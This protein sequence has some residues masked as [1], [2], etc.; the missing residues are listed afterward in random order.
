MKLVQ[1]EQIIFIAVY[2]TKNTDH[3]WPGTS[4]LVSDITCFQGFFSYHE[5]QPILRHFCV[6]HINAPGQDDGAL[7]LKPEYGLSVLVVVAVVSPVFSMPV[8]VKLLEHW[9]SHVIICGRWCHVIF[10]SSYFLQRRL[11]NPW[12]CT[13]RVHTFT[14]VARG[15]M[16][17][18][19]R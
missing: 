2:L 12:S 10:Q 13:S 17:M 9:Y 1:K 3:C 4:L 11:L 16:C 7:N 6:Y 14:G 18:L 15:S 8:V 19:E 5:M